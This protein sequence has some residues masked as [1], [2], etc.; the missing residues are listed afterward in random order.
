MLNPEVCRSQKMAVANGGVVVTCT[1]TMEDSRLWAIVMK[2]KRRTKNKKN[3]VL[4][5]LQSFDV[6]TS[7]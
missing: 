5:N 6:S 7:L 3:K 1:P 2:K 4:L